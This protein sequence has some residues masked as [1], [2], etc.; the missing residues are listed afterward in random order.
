MEGEREVDPEL[1]LDE[2]EVVSEG[3]R[4]SLQEYTQR[5]AKLQN[6]QA[7]AELEA[8]IGAAQNSTDPRVSARCAAYL[9]QRAVCDFLAK[10]AQ[11]QDYKF[12]LVMKVQKIVRPER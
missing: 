9:Q 1:E 12:G 3:R 5:F 4:W 2:D 8:L 7:L 11:G 6:A 10:S